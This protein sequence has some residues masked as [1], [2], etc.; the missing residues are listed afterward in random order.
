[1]N[2]GV[3]KF[4]ALRIWH[5]ACQRVANVY[6]DFKNGPGVRDF[7]FKDQIQRARISRF[8]LTSYEEPET[9]K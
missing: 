4:G 3:Q 2:E 1:M 5:E 8:F 9:L 6:S 7:G